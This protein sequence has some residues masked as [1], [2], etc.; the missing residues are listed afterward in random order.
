MYPTRRIG[1]DYDI[2]YLSTYRRIFSLEGNKMKTL[3]VT[4]TTGYGG[5]AISLTTDLVY[6][7][8][9][10]LL[11]DQDAAI[12][13]PY[14]TTGI[15]QDQ[16]HE[17]NSKLPFYLWTMPFST[18]YKGGS[19]QVHA[20][21]Y[22]VVKEVTA[23]LF[24]V[25]AY[26]RIIR[27]EEFTHI[28]LNS[29]VFWSLLPFLPK[30]VK[31]I[32]HVRELISDDYSGKIA[33]KMINRY[34]DTIIAISQQTAKGFPR[35]VVVENPYDMYRARQYRNVRAEVKSQMGI[36]IDSFIVSVFS[37]IGVQKGSDFLVKVINKIPKE[38]PIHFLL[39][40]N[41]FRGEK[42]TY[43]ALTRISNVH[44]FPP[45]KEMYKYYAVSDIVLRCEP[46]LPLGRTVYEGIY[47]GCITVLPV[48]EG[49]EGGAKEIMKYLGRQ[50][51]LYKASDPESCVRTII[52]Y[53]FATHKNG[54]YDNGFE[55][56]TNIKE[57]AEKFLSVIKGER[58]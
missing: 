46:Y 42:E 30:E 31:K 2:L 55:P 50:M 49:E 43:D 39:V 16:Y 10:G 22:S 28:H 3:F 45:S 1:T 37:P 13:A 56:T 32:V 27:R 11:K 5:A 24:W 53:V 34:A 47:A 40:G 33:R 6:L 57:S 25:G 29:T 20:K 36:P 12:A 4:H 18:A 19:V 26:N 44:I 21:L 8:E 41:P 54:V 23:I 35:A 38:V 58:K 17:F 48:A 14:T 15:L 7:L 51:F 52:N 9:N